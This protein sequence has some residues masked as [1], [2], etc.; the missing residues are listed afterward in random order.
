[1]ETTVYVP[2]STY[3]LSLKNKFIF[4]KIDFKSIQIRK[5]FSFFL[6]SLF[7]RCSTYLPTYTTIGQG[8]S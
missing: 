3:L 7:S 1:M 5:I 2:M 4:I 6:G 8:R